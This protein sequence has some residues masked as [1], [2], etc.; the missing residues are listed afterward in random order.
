MNPITS[1]TVDLGR[2]DS[3]SESSKWI[4]SREIWTFNLQE[5]LVGYSKKTTA[6]P[7]IAKW[8]S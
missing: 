7:A 6:C 1:S 2:K 3:T 8:E 5:K 4:E